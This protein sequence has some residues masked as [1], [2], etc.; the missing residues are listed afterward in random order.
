MRRDSRN[1]AFILSCISVYQR[2]FGRQVSSKMKG[3][4]KLLEIHRQLVKDG[5]K[6]NFIIIS[7]QNVLV[8]KRRKLEKFVRSRS[9]SGFRE[10]SNAMSKF[11]AAFPA[12]LPLTFSSPSLC[13][14]DMVGGRGHEVAFSWQLQLNQEGLTK[15][16]EGRRRDDV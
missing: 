16:G 6:Q 11:C 10:I 7:L 14:P 12:G 13:W 5:G 15:K 8:G 4:G 9:D 2:G 3:L 1:L